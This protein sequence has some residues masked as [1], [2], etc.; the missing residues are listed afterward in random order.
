MS[1]K[2]IEMIE[3]ADGRLISSDK[4]L[5][6][7]REPDLFPEYLLPFFQSKDKV[8]SKNI[9][10]GCE[11]VVLFA[12][13]RMGVFDTERFNY[14]KNVGRVECFLSSVSLPGEIETYPLFVRYRWGWIVI[15]P[16]E[17]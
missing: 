4:T 14:I 7:V 11:R 3:E 10:V 8:M 5:M 16:M 2:K 15:S 6:K 13:D 9:D 12:G 17:V 1:S